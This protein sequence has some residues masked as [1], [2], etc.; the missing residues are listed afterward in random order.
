MPTSL[1]AARHLAVVMIRKLDEHQGARALRLRQRR[2]VAGQ[3]ER[4][5]HARVVVGRRLEVAV[6]VGHDD[7]LLGGGAGQRRLGPG[8]L[9]VRELGHREPQRDR[10]RFAGAEPVAQREAFVLG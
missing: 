4:S 1:A 7:D 6:G 2:V 9:D 8:G 5:S 3:L 10:D